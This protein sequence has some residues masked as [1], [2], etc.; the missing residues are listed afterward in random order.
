MPQECNWDN[1]PVVVAAYTLPYTFVHT[2]FGATLG[3]PQPST[4]TKPPVGQISMVLV[5]TPTAPTLPHVVSDGRRPLLSP[6]SGSG[7][8]ESEALPE[9]VHE[10]SPQLR[11]GLRNR[12]KLAIKK[13]WQRLTSRKVREIAVSGPSRSSDNASHLVRYVKFSMVARMYRLTRL[14]T[15]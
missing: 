13:V 10:E 15:W 6:S 3:P 14:S 4:A 5:D 2:P 8:Q 7:G 11:R 1:G 9:E 12:S